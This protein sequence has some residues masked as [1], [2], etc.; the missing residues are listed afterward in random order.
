MRAII[1]FPVLI[2]GCL[3][4]AGCATPLEV[5][6][7]TSDILNNSSDLLTLPQTMVVPDT[8]SPLVTS[9]SYVPRSTVS[10]TT[11]SSPTDPII[12]NWK[13]STGAPYSCSASV[14]EDNTGAISCELIYNKDIAWENLGQD[15]NQTWMTDYNITDTSSNEVYSAQ[16]SSM[17][18]KLYSGIL[19]GGTY[20][21]RV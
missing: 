5:K 8:L 18:D 3:L 16:Y 15:Q 6:Q 20:F 7:D 2:I 21:V 14:L 19:P 12:G 9:D 1:L 17:T 11:V 10:K 4:I 13:L